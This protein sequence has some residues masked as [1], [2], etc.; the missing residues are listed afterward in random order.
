[1]AV[2]LK[3][4]DLGHV[5]LSIV[6]DGLIDSGQKHGLPRS[7]AE[8]C[9]V[10]HQAKRSL[11]KVCAVSSQLTVIDVSVWITCKNYRMRV[12]YGISIS[13]PYSSLLTWGKIYE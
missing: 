8:V 11:I 12:T 3:H 5:A 7:I 10:V 6:E 4:H 1:M 2:L 13:F 9:R